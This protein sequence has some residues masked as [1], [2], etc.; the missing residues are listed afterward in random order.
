MLGT[1]ADAK[2]FMPDA[3]ADF[4]YY[5]MGRFQNTSIPQFQFLASVADTAQ[6]VVMALVKVG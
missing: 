2:D 1:E 3:V 5:E 6:V 4:N